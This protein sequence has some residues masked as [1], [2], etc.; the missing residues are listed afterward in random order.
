MRGG[1]SG[2]V[3]HAA[4]GLRGS[5]QPGNRHEGAAVL[6][7]RVD[8]ARHRGHRALVDVVQQMVPS[9]PAW[10]G[11]RFSVGAESFVEKSPA[12]VLQRVRER[13]SPL[14]IP[15]AVS[16]VRP[17]GGRVSRSFLP[18]ISAVAS[19]VFSGSAPVSSGFFP[20]RI[21]CD[22]HLLP[23]EGVHE[24]RS[25]LAGAGV[26]RQGDARGLTAVHRS[27]RP[28]GVGGGVGA[29]F[30]APWSASS[31]HRASVRG[32]SSMRRTAPCRTRAS[33]RAQQTQRVTSRWLG[34][35]GGAVRR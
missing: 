30:R 27:E 8:D 10:S 14:L 28:L 17:C 1:S 23:L 4:P 24:M 25:V 22:R 3:D 34:R 26:E 20:V 6:L 16:S 5:H 19:C 11:V 7:Q 32:T 31:I 21:W 29:R 35:T 15:G 9:L 18:V 13:P 2:A 33:F 12:V